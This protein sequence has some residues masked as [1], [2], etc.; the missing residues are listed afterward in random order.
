MR[1]VR[2]QREEERL[3]RLEGE[4]NEEINSDEMDEIIYYNIVIVVAL[5]LYLQILC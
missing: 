5:C 1:N 4:E 2:P 3:R